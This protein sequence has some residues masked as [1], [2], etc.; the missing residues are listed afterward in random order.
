MSDH[1]LLG[2][3]VRY[4]GRIYYDVL[5]TNIKENTKTRGIDTQYGEYLTYGCVTLPVDQNRFVV[6][7]RDYG[8]L[9]V[10]TI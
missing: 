9:V 10:D 4:N 5:V 7:Q 2:Q 3:K 1:A 8:W 6:I